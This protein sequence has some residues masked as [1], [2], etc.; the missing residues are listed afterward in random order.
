MKNQ[1][2]KYRVNQ[3]I[4]SWKNQTWTSLNDKKKNS[5]SQSRKRD[6]SRVK[7]DDLTLSTSNLLDA[8]FAM[9]AF[10]SAD[11]IYSIRN[12]WMINNESNIHICNESMNHRFH[13]ERQKNNDQVL[14]DDHLTKIESY[15]TIKLIVQTLNESN[16]ITFTNV[17]YIPSFMTNVVSNHLL[18]IKEV[19]LDDWKKHIHRE[20]K[21]IVY[22]TKYKAHYLLKNNVRV[23]FSTVKFKNISTDS[24]TFIKNK[25]TSSINWYQMLEHVFF[26]VIKHLQ[27]S[28]KKMKINSIIEMFKTSACDSC[29]LSKIHRIISQSTENIESST[30]FLV[31]STSRV[32]NRIL[33]SNSILEHLQMS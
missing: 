20:E 27:V 25:I 2:T 17:T 23:V 26:K 21:T 22:V 16:L 8:V 9:K 7:N 10:F 18:K 6:R 11:D 33:C 31:W 28:A 14:A 13:L 15:D 32:L 12:S 4:E 29:A 3:S 5:Q 24:K 30:V 19:F 1:M